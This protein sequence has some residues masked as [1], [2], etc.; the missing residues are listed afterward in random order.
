MALR[1]TVVGERSGPHQLAIELVEMPGPEPGQRHLA[2]VGNG[3]A[4]NELLVPDPGPRANRRLDAVKPGAEE[5]LHRDA[6]VTEDLAVP[7]GLERHGQ[8]LRT[9][10]R[11]LP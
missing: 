8:L 2:D 1:T 9:S 11:V 6:L 3:V 10:A 5:L 4:S 7:M